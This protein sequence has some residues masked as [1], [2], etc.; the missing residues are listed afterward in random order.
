M[1]ICLGSGG[2]DEVQTS[3][4]T[5]IIIKSLSNRLNRIVVWVHTDIYHWFFLQW[6]DTFSIEKIDPNLMFYMF[7]LQ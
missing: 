2:T 6:L 4:S 1:L 7:I 5:K 3:C